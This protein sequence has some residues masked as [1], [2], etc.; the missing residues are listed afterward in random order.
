MAEGWCFLPQ[1]S[2]G[3]AIS[4]PLGQWESLEIYLQAAQIEIDNNLV[5]NAIRPA[6]LGKNYGS[7]SATPTLENVAR[8]STRSL[9]AAAATVSKPTH[10]T[11]VD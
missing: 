4:Y 7:S 5:E 2:V 1:S 9:K 11:I 10:H 3:K 8:S 6:A